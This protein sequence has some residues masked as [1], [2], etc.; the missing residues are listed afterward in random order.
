[1]RKKIKKKSF[2][3]RIPQNPSTGVFH[4]R[5]AGGGRPFT[6]CT[7]LSASTPN[8]TD[9]PLRDC[10]R[11]PHVL[12]DDAMGGMGELSVPKV[13]KQTNDILESIT[14]WT[15]VAES[16]SGEKGEEKNKT[17][18]LLCT[19][20]FHALFRWD[21]HIHWLLSSSLCCPKAKKGEEK[22]WGIYSGWR[23][24]IPKEGCQFHMQSPPKRALKVGYLFFLQPSCINAVKI[25]V[26]SLHNST[27]EKSKPCC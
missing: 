8:S 16:I 11:D 12:W 23:G 13:L 10:L 15:H 6:C 22:C 3:G 7:A 18:T 21:R 2:W 14:N 25:N 19:G 20:H 4:T 27:S 1:M 26:T 5:A 17:Q 24:M 9:R